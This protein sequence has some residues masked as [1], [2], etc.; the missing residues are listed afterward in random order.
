MCHARDLDHITCQLPLLR[1][2]A[3][4]STG[5][6][7]GGEGEGKGEE[8][9]CAVHVIAPASSAPARDRSALQPNKSPNVDIDSIGVTQLMQSSVLRDSWCAGVAMAMAM[10]MEEGVTGVENVQGIP[11]HAIPLDQSMQ[12]IFQQYL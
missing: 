9:V 10:A 4:Q 1:E 6:G 7:A 12:H 5:S 2:I 8:E 11:A 3:L